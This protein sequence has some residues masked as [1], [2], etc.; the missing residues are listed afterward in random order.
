MNAN[1]PSSKSLS[2][3]HVLRTIAWVVFLEAVRGRLLWLVVAILVIG[4]GLAEFIADV[5][6]TGSQQ[7]VRGLLGSW[8]RASAVFVSALFVATSMVRD[9]NDK[10]T[11]L[12]LALPIPRAVYLFGRLAGYWYVVLVTAML[13]GALILLY[14]PFEQ[15][16]IWTLSLL[17]ELTLIVAL[18]V[19]CLLTLN[20]ITLSMSAVMGF[21]LLARSMG[22]IQLIGQNPLLDLSSVS[23]QV[24]T[25]LL[26]CLAY[27]LPNLNQFTLSQWLIYE[28]ATAGDLIPIVLQS[29]VYVLLLCAAS[30]F[31]LQRKVL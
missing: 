30:L 19:L 9:F 13:C 28:S 16:L 29:F 4:L 20:H 1:T 25:F 31:D 17:C 23:Q 3:G 12:I 2:H 18:A 27:I 5:A 14:V 26:T 8:L 22:A 7:I 21:Y 24:I 6:I 15:A 11:E 10:G